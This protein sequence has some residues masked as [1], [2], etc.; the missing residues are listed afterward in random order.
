MSEPERLGFLVLGSYS[1]TRAGDY[2]AVGVGVVRYGVGKRCYICQCCGGEE[3]GA[4]K[5]P[6]QLLLG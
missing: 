6:R 3:S 5:M 2:A 1:I 4:P